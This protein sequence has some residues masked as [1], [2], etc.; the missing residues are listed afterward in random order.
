M[1]RYQRKTTTRQRSGK[2]KI[3]WSAMPYLELAAMIGLLVAIVAARQHPFEPAIEDDEQIARAHLLDAQLGNALLAVLPRIRQHRVAVAADQ[4]FQRQLDRQ[5]E[6][7]R[8]QRL[9]TGNRV[10]PVQLE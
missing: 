9:N 10:P 5:I 8:Q 1:R 7:M 3:A 2:A 4:A 6:V